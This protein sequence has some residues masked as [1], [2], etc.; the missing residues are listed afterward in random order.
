MPRP[1]LEIGTYGQIRY[2]PTP[3]GWRARTLFRDF[4]GSTPEVERSGKTKGQAA[5]RLRDAIR[6]W[7]GSSAGEITRETQLKDVAPVWLD[8]LR[9]DVEEGKKSPTTIT[10][11]ESILNR[12]VIPGVGE[13]RVREATVMRLDRF[14]GA[15]QRNVGASTAKTARTALSG[16]LSLAARYDAIDTNPTRD[17]RRIPINKKRPRALNATERAEWLKRLEAN[18]KAVRWDLPDLSRFMMATGVRVGEALATYWEDID[19]KAGTVDITHT[20][21]RLKGEGL[22]RKPQPKSESSLRALPMPSWAVKMLRRKAKAVQDE[23]GTLTGPIFPSTTG[24][25]RDPSNVLRVIREIRGGD[26]FLWVTSH[27]FRKTT[28]TALDD[29]GVA[30]RLIADHLGHARVSMTQDNY[31]ERKVV[32]PVTAEA[33]E[34]LLDNPSDPKTGDKPGR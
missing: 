11:Y 1:R 33:L 4:D 6:E 14:L 13:L 19:L 22:Y 8:Q 12:H 7:K 18:E 30:T 21:V 20:V 32:D 16:M 24:G 29:A 9:Q 23:G 17:T 27:T 10:T 25:L 2:S 15:L 3:N 5:Q 34:G 26:H 31:L 28:A